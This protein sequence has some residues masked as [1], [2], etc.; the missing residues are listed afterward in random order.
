MGKSITF[1]SYTPKKE[2]DWVDKF[3]PYVDLHNPCGAIE[4]VEDVVLDNGNLKSMYRNH[5]VPLINL[6]AGT[7][8]FSCWCWGEKPIKKAF[9]KQVFN[10]NYYGYI[11]AK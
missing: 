7:Y 5:K 10:T 8:T 1:G 9:R 3:Y 6:A 11:K 4:R 2:D